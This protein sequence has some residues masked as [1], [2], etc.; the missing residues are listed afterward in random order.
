MSRRL[1]PKMRTW[2]FIKNKVDVGGLKLDYKEGRNKVRAFVVEGDTKF[3]INLFA[4]SHRRVRGQSPTNDID[5]QD[6]ITNYKTQVDTVPPSLSNPVILSNVDMIGNK[7][8]IH[9]S[10][11]PSLN[12]LSFATVWT[13]AGDDVTNHII[14]GGPLMELTLTPGT[15]SVSVEAE[16]DAAFGE[17][18]L[19]EGYV[20][21]ETAGWGDYINNS[22]FSRPT[23]LQTSI[24]L[25][26]EIV[27]NKV[28]YATGGAGT[29]THGFASTP[30]LVPNVNKTG[31]WNYN[32]TLT[33]NLTQ[34]GAY[35]IY[36]IEVEVNRFHNKVPLFGS[37]TAFNMLQSADSSLVPN[38]YFLRITAYN[39]SNTTWKVWFIMTL[40][41]E[42]TV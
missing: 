25:D 20:M 33:P 29:G 30:V 5:Y 9:E 11:R 36:D 26:Y 19:H 17:V 27:S 15:L 42:R 10:S 4:P 8:A 12:G 7:L 31:Y 28:K 41:R 34:T 24:N 16:F 32:G 22:V 35:D 3:F 1:T 13:G 18:W 23:L 6:F 2:A 14:G 39:M 37:A 38:N 21:W 40:Y